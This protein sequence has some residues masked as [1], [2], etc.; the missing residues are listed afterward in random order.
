M[1]IVLAFF[2]L[3]YGAALGSPSCKVVQD[4]SE[5]VDTLL[6]V[7]TPGTGIVSCIGNSQLRSFLISDSI[8]P[9]CLRTLTMREQEAL[10]LRE[11][12][13]ELQKT[14][15]YLTEANTLLSARGDTLLVTI[16]R[17]EEISQKQDTLNGLLEERLE[18][19]EKNSLSLL[20]KVIGAV[21]F[22][23]AGSLIGVVVGAAAF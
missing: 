20:D 21:G 16:K 22:F 9:E 7:S 12:K 5:G 14:V 18:Y 6:V 8:A 2:I 19:C 23:L 10:V 13:G 11:Q 3:L 1:R 15:G 17:Q 4:I